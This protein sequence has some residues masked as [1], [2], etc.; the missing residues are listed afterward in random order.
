LKAGYEIQDW[1][2][3][4]QVFTDASGTENADLILQ[5]LTIDVRFDF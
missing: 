5:G 3:H 1:L 4:F 2:N